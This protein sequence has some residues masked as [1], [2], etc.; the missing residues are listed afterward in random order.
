MMKA[1]QKIQVIFL[2][3]NCDSCW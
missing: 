2:H 3:Y 1:Q